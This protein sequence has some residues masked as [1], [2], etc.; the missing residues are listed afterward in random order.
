MRTFMKHHRRSGPRSRPL[1]VWILSIFN[2]LYVWILAFLAI[3]SL[4]ISKKAVPLQ[5]FTKKQREKHCKTQWKTRQNI[6]I[7]THDISRQL[8]TK[9]RIQRD[10]KHAP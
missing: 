8:R 6:D 7:T 1:F 4:I 9:D 2:N 10:Q 3:N 5:R